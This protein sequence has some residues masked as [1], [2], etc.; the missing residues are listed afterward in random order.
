[1]SFRQSNVVTGHQGVT[2]V[3]DLYP[4][5]STDK[6]S[7][8]LL[9]GG[10]QNRHAWAK[11]ARTIHAAGHHVVAYDAR[12]H[13]DSSWDPAGR[14]DT[15][16]LAYD[17]LAVRERYCGR[18][19]AVAVGASL[20]GMTIL[21]AHRIAPPRLWAG[22]VLVDVTPRMELDGARRVVQFMS[23]HP[24]GFATLEDAGDVIAAYNPHRPRPDNIDG[25][26]KVLRQRDD[27]RWVWRW[28]PAF[29]T[30]KLD[31]MHTDPANSAHRF[32]Q[33]ADELL[34]GARR[35][36]APAL[37]VRGAMSDL[38]SRETADE[39]LAAVPHAEAVD[40]SDTGHMVAGDDNDSFTTA[41]LAFLDRIPP[42]PNPHRP[43]A[44]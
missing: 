17:L 15:E 37:L 1:M 18:R 14:Y 16:D 2:L 36:T 44:Q 41:V 42:T 19:P 25:L 24:D 30:S 8:I 5:P 38:V 39:F 33:M 11:T 29:I 6:P 27:G 34:D 40:V 3:A 31:V 7:V 10:G 32:Q 4:Q 13:G 35:I 28:D 9:H 26:T 43:P 12:G 23:A 21:T 20:G 22:V